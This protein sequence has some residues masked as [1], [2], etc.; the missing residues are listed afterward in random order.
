MLLIIMVYLIGGAPRVGKSTLTKLMLER[1]KI[2][3]VDADWIIFMLMH[4][5]PQLGVAAFTDLNLAEFKNKAVNFYPF[6][7]EFVKYNQPVIDK[8]I[9]EGDSFLPEH[10]I[11]LQNEFQVRACF[12]GTSKL[13][14]EILLDNPSSNNWIK[15][16]TH[17]QLIVLCNWVIE[18][19]EYL[20]KE[21]AVNNIM[22]F[23]VANNYP[24]QLEKAYQYLIRA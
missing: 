1:D 10:V 2:G 9:V 14:P 4:A 22:Y 5:A 17:E 19:S 6:L 23:D 11:S 13:S 8:Y 7:H 20:K 21:C 12:L 15:K 16:L 24:G 3:Y 18:T